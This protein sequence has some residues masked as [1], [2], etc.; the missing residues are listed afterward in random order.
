MVGHELFGLA[1]LIVTGTIILASF[2]N[3]SGT[4]QV[5]KAGGDSFSGILN[6]MQGGGAPA[7]TAQG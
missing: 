6:A 7:G 1:A 4:S 2:R 3:G 5:L